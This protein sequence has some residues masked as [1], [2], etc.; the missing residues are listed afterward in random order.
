MQDRAVVA[1]LASETVG[2]EVGEAPGVHQTLICRTV[3]DQAATVDLLCSGF[4]RTSVVDTPVVATTTAD[5]HHH[6]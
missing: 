2:G 4:R 3:G 6:A 1:L 5:R